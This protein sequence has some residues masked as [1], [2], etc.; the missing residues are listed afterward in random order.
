MTT[1]D[2]GTVLSAEEVRVVGALV[3]K[4]VTTP[5]YYPLTL[6]ALVNACNQISNRDPVVSYD[7]QTVVRAIDTLREKNLV[8][9]VRTADGRV[10]KYRQVLEEAITLTKA[11]LAVVCVLMLRGAQTPG[12]LRGRT[13]RLYPF[14]GVQFVEATLED[15]MRRT[16]PLVARLPRGA[17]QKEA[18]YAHLLAGE[19]KLDEVEAGKSHEPATAARGARAGDERVSRL[20][21]EVG[22]LRGELEELKR[23]FAE[24]RRQFE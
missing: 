19:L 22:A 10:P 2:E 8:R 11:E 6:N 7:E 13:E 20:E 3:E 5:E 21:E 17:G 16:P 23:E 15:L 24:F 9:E 14:S 4:Q 18:R 12:E 1:F